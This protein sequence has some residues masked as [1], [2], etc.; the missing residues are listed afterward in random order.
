MPCPKCG[1]ANARGAIECGRCGV[2]FSKVEDR[3]SGLSGQARLPV[4]HVVAD[5]R[6]GPA[7][8]KI[9]G[10]GLALAVVAY[11]IPFT[12]FV[13]SAL[14]TLFH[15]LGHAVTGWLLGHPSLPAFDFVYGGGFT[16]M[17]QFRPLLAT[18]IGLGFA[19]LLWLFRENR[20]AMIL[21]AI[22]AAVWLVFVTKEWR[23]ELAIAAAGHAW[24]FILAAIF[25]YKSLAGVGWK[26]PD[27]ERPLGAFVA[28]FVQIHSTVFA[29][30]LINDG[31]FLELYREGKGG[32]LM[33]D[34]EVIALD[35]NIHLAFNPEITGVARM[36]L[37]FS[38]L[39]TAV[40]LIWFFERARW[41]R[42]LRALRTVEVAVVL[43][44][45]G[46][47]FAGEP[48]CGVSEERDL[49]VRLNHERARGRVAANAATTLPATL[50][51]GAFYLRTD[52]RIATGARYF[53]LEGQSL[54]FEP[55]GG[56]KF[57]VTRTALQYQDP[58]S[59]VRDF[60]PRTGSPWH[61]VPYD[62]GAFAFPIFG[63]SVTRLYLTAFNEIEL[64]EPGEEP[65]ASFNELEAAVHRNAVLSP[66]IITNRKPR[67]LAYPQ[68]FVRETADALY[69]TWQSTAGDTFGYDV[70]AALHRDG[71]VTYSYKSM[72]EM[73][74]GTPLLTPGFDPAAASRTT[75]HAGNLGAGHPP[76]LGALGPMVD[77]RKVEVSRVNDSDLL[78]IRLTVN[79]AIDASKLADGQAL[80]YVV[81]INNEPTYV[82]VNRTGWRVLPFRAISSVSQGSAVQ[83]A[84]NTVELYLLQPAGMT[85]PQMRVFTQLRPATSSADGYSFSPAVGPAPR[86]TGVDLS[87]ASG[88][89]TAP[90]AETFTLPDLDPYEVWNRI[91]PAFAISD[92][93]VD[94]VAIYQNFYTDMIFYAGAYATS[95]NPGVTGIAPSSPT[96]GAHARRMPTLLHMNHFTYN[97]NATPETASQ[98]L[99]HE[100]G[101]RWLYF[102]RIL[103]GGALTNSLNPVSA[104]PAAFVHAPAAF[105]VFREGESSTMGGAVFT[106]E[107]GNT[108]RARVSNRGFS[109]IDLYLMGLAAPEE[110][111]PWFYLAG[112][113]LRGE[114][115]PEDNVVVTGEKREVSIDQIVAA[116]GDRNPS[117]SLAQKKFRLLFVLVTEGE[118]S[119]ADAAKL[120]EWREVLEQTFYRAT[121]G[122]GI[123]ETELVRP[124]KR[125]AGR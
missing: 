9:L 68:L 56:A 95:G 15:E 7:E 106:N 50:R 100:L 93:E 99:L 105:P 1:F 49:L 72:R 44:V 40:A 66:L 37:V 54:R 6:I 24:E 107:G 62:L 92:Y 122:R 34:L 52:D 84:G 59:L 74:W 101:H 118:P 112:T 82:D 76:Q 55:R 77:L 43:A 57:A 22:A 125:R 61:A 123:V 63:R 121:G 60:A 47:A 111:M 89:V 29:W 23:R 91:K 19:Y 21:I 88:E 64:G 46:A 26:H 33:N 73:R 25:F 11:V 39:P 75:L 58:G 80:R 103:E 120:N 48:M 14:I 115:W 124:A 5:G 81:T 45:A 35:L 90:L 97:Y 116:H 83:I 86:S 98:V 53:D 114:Y 87:A 2:I 41:H 113:G 12:R 20:K 38:I 4:L 79:A 96:Y 27:I 71:S 108:Y 65:S 10:I 13:F 17:G 119:D 3:Q 32:A 36:L 8:W 67:Q 85:N 109:W 30:R 104:H 18:A 28:F 16:H 110:V 31:G 42:L 69:V 51:D 102:F 78:A 94:A 70:Q 117:A